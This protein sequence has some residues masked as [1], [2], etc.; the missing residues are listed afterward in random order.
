MAVMLK[1]KKGIFFTLIAIMLVTI[2]AVAFS[3]REH[4][5]Y[6]DRIPAV[7]TRIDIANDYVRMVKYS[8]L[9]SAIETSGRNALVALI[10]F[11]NKTTYMPDFD[12][13]N[14]TFIELMMNGTINGTP[15]EC[16]LVVPTGDPVSTPPL[17]AS[18]CTASLDPGYKVM[19]DRALLYKL[20]AIENASMDTLHIKTRFDKNSGNYS[21]KIYQSNLTG[22]WKVGVNLSTNYTIDASIA[23]WNITQDVET[24]IPIEGL[25]DPIYLKE[26]GYN[27]TIISTNTTQ[28]NL[29]NLS[30]FIYDGRYRLLSEAPSFTMRLYHNL[31]NGGLTASGSICCGIESAVNPDRLNINKCTRKSYIDWCFYGNKCEPDISGS[32]NAKVWNITSITTY[33]GFLG[34]WPYRQY[35]GFKLDSAHLSVYNVT[36]AEIEGMGACECANPL[37]C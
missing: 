17:E 31:S 15:I 9:P 23:Y 26:A 13:V 20:A 22:P 37:T 32:P 14:T 24:T 35:T 8:Y 16:Y 4:I 30:Q 2:L 29:S 18:T 28:W 21:V 6:K 7:T 11:E 25:L 33:P 36:G 3:P 19:K 1:G 12:A 27:N 34:G 5:T 10:L